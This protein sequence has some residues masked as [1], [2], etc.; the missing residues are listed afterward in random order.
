MLTKLAVG[1]KGFKENKPSQRNIGSY[2]R[3]GN[4][5]NHESCL[6]IVERFEQSK[7]S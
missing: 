7:P 1:S 2:D 3:K 4:L 5:L 6:Q